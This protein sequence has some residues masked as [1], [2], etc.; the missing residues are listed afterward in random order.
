MPSQPA[1]FFIAQLPTPDVAHVNDYPDQPGLVTFSVSDGGTTKNALY[2]SNMNGI[3]NLAYTA[4]PF[5]TL[6]AEVPGEG[7]GGG[8]TRKARVVY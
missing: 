2:A 4:M 7:G 5:N 8:G 3:G 6:P 1:P